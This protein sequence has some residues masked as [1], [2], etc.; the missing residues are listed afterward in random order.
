MGSTRHA[1]IPV[2]CMR[3]SRVR[4]TAPAHWASIRHR[5]PSPETAGPN[6]W[7][8][9]SLVND[10]SRWRRACRRDAC[11]RPVAMRW[12]KIRRDAKRPRIGR[13]PLLPPCRGPEAVNA[14]RIE[15]RLAT[16]ARLLHF[17]E[18]MACS[19]ACAHARAGKRAVPNLAAGRRMAPNRLL[20]API[21]LQRSG[22]S[23]ALAHALWWTLMHSALVLFTFIG[24]SSLHTPLTLRTVLL[25]YKRI[26]LAFLFCL[27]CLATAASSVRAQAKFDLEPSLEILK[28]SLRIK[29]ESFTPRDCAFEMGCVLGTGPRK[30]LQLAGAIGN[31]GPDDFVVGNPADHPDIYTWDTCTGQFITR[32]PMLNYSIWDS[33]GNLVRSGKKESFCMEDLARFPEY[34]GNPALVPAEP[35]HTC[36]FQGISVG[37]CDIYDD[38]LPCQWIDITGVPSGHY[39]LR[40]EC[41]AYHI[42][43]ETTYANNVVET[44]VTIT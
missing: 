35:V 40:L 11:R 42:F 15:E 22:R 31:N 6:W 37:W 43:K 33:A 12:S 38:S 4:H 23:M 24:E 19:D 21:L 16:I 27:V 41:N 13:S 25:M 8:H 18:A 28:G 1:R 44:P 5:R 32:K 34:T 3:A 17:R 26:A 39:T 2:S 20:E 14:T 29:T 7:T 36:T 10:T 9:A 30:L